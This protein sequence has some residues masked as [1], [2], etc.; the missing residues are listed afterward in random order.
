MEQ[1]F[2]YEIFSQNFPDDSENRT[3]P[4]NRNLQ[5]LRKANGFKS[6]KAFAEELGMSNSTYTHYEQNELTMPLGVAIQVAD[7]FD[8]SID[9]LVGRSRNIGPGKPDVIQRKIESLDRGEREFVYEVID[10]MEI[11][12]EKHHK[13]DS[14]AMQQRYKIDFEHELE[15]FCNLTGYDVSSIETFADKEV[16]KSFED[17]L[18]LEKATALKN[19]ADNLTK[20][21][22]KSQKANAK[23]TRDETYLLHRNP[24]FM[25]GNKKGFDDGLKDY[26]ARRTAENETWIQGIMK[27]Y[28]A[29]FIVISF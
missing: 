18:C 23:L 19:H 16:R 8:C 21:F 1:S 2:S 26:V 11:R 29:E 9:D 4:S 28:D 22:T 3:T 10:L 20:V 5:A 7:C 13:E 15:V 6:A 14:N 12:K 25:L 27:A 24:S 17:H